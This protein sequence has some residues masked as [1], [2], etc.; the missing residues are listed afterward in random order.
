MFSDTRNLVRQPYF[1]FCPL[2]FPFL[3]FTQT[4]RSNTYRQGELQGGRGPETLDAKK[5]ALWT[6]TPKKTFWTQTP[7]KDAREAIDAVRQKK[8][9]LDAD[10]ILK[11]LSGRRRQKVYRRQTQK[12]IACGRR[13]LKKRPLDARRK[14]Y[15]PP[16]LYTVYQIEIVLPYPPVLKQFPLHSALLA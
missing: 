8:W 4:H 12:K 6:Q 1:P 10:A 15:N 16:P 14:P 13:R 11:L 7:T 2:P 9:L 3:L 5:K